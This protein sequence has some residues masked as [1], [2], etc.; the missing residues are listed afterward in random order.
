MSDIVLISGSP[1]ASSRTVTVLNAMAAHLQEAGRQTTLLHARE[2]SD[3]Q[4]QQVKDSLGLIA[5]CKAVVVGSPIYKA[6][7][8]GLLKSFLDLLPPDALKGKVAMP[9]ATGA[10]PGHALAIEHELSP[11]LFALGAD[12]VVRGQY[13]VDPDLADGRLS[14]A[15]ATALGAASVRLLAFGGS[16]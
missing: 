5:R 16:K 8:T 1:S 6:S 3:P 10:A 4:S 12:A 9:V 7:L 14:A 13:F 15:A 11:L 2:L